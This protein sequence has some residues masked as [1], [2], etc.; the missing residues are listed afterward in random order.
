VAATRPVILSREDGEGSSNAESGASEDPSLRSERV[1]KRIAIG[2][3]P[4]RRSEAKDG[5]GIPC[6]TRDSLGRQ[7]NLGCADRSLQMHIEQKFGYT[8][9]TRVGEKLA[10]HEKKL[11]R[12]VEKLTRDEKKLTRV[13]EKLTRHVKKLTRH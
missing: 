8:K 3:I 10:T 9:L 12:H 11:E 1:K 2:A 13:G 7:E 4:S 5:R 6:D